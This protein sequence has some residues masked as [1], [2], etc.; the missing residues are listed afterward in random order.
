MSGARLT[1][2]ELRRLVSVS[3]TRDRAVREVPEDV[4]PDFHLHDPVVHKQVINH[5][6]VLLF[7][8][9]AEERDIAWEFYQAY[10]HLIENRPLTEINLKLIDR[11]V[12]IEFFYAVKT[13]NDSNA[14][15]FVE[16]VIETLEDDD[17]DNEDEEIDG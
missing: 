15:L 9:E 8:S 2:R 11:D 6:F 4:V 14:E 5:L 10:R 16:D 3:N 17:E 1:S 13:A 12:F 7:T